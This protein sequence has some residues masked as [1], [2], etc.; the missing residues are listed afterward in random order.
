MQVGTLPFMLGAVTLLLVFV[1][2]IFIHQLSL[3]DD[4]VE[5]GIPASGNVD[6]DTIDVMMET[7]D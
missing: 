2:G 3:T 7:S 6:V 5:E 1:V 4:L